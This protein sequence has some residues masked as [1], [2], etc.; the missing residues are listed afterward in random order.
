MWPCFL[1]LTFRPAQHRFQGVA[2]LPFAN[3]APGP[4]PAAPRSSEPGAGASP[5]GRLQDT[6]SS[7]DLLTR[8]PRELAH[9]SVHQGEKESQHSEQE[10]RDAWEESLH[11]QDAVATRRVVSGPGSR[12]LHSSEHV[13][14]L[15]RPPCSLWE[16]P[17]NVKM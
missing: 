2:G 14:R 1:S 15:L 5:T 3:T 13:Q 17:Q 4:T 8:L 10:V 12:G 11:A 9:D 6:H 16:F 7:A